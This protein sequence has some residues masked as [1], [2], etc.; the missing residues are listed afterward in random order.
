MNYDNM[1]DAAI[2]SLLIDTMKEHES[3]H[4]VIGWLRSSYCSPTHA[5]IERVVA[6]KK[7]QEYNSEVV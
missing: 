7:L 1:T 6:I 4:F 3:L 5:D 2:K